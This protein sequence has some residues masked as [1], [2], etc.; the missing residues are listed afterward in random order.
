MAF[1]ITE[2]GLYK[3]KWTVATN[4]PVGSGINKILT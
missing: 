2:A 3:S 1:N 4:L